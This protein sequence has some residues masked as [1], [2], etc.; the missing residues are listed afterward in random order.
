[1]K[2][3]HAE[4]KA[5][6]HQATLLGCVARPE[7][8]E[9]SIKQLKPI[10]EIGNLNTTGESET[11]SKHKFNKIVQAHICICVYIYICIY[12]YINI[13][14]YIYI[15]MYI[16]IYVYMYICIMYVYMYVC[17]CVCMHA[18]IQ[19]SSLT[20]SL[21]GVSH[22]GIPSTPGRPQLSH[23]R[24]SPLRGNSL[25]GQ[26]LGFKLHIIAHLCR[27]LLPDVPISCI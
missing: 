15:H 14:I 18:Q 4:G 23:V 9:R 27:C 21:R 13:Y 16:C 3:Q 5:L 11:W 12:M 20:Q 8:L 6:D 10:P 24:T 25:G 2:L 19:L 26:G 7:E 1:M 17:V 22:A